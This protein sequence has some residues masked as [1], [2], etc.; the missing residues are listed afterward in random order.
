M[1]DVEKDCLAMLRKNVRVTGRLTALGITRSPEAWPGTW[2]HDKAAR[3][4][5]GLVV[6]WGEIPG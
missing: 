3:I 2:R 1:P 4:S 6:L 5:G